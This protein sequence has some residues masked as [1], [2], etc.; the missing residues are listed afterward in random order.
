MQE[1]AYH[2]ADA[3]FG[4]SEEPVPVE[5]PLADEAAMI[6][7]MRRYA[8]AKADHEER[9]KRGGEYIRQVKAEVEEDL[10]AGEER[11]ER[12][13]SSMLTFVTERN[14]GRKFSVPGL[15]TATTTTRTR[16]DIADEE[17]FLAALPESEREDLFD[18]KLNLSR[19]KAAARSAVEETGEQP[20]GVE[21]ERVTSLSVRPAAG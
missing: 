2:P 1:E 7:I 4:L 18:R 11:L 17:R 19:A 21:A 16:V 13:R 5:E 15:C 8:V 10:R 20:P 6:E 3:A 14:G 12:M 9:K